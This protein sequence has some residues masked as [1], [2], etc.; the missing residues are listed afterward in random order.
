MEYLCSKEGSSEYT[1]HILNKSLTLIDLFKIF[2]SCMP[3]IEIILEHLPRLL[4]RSYS[5]VNSKQNN[6]NFLKICFSVMD[7]G[8]D[9]KGLTTGW[10][11]EIILKKSNIEDKM[12]QLS[13]NNKSIEVPI[14]IRKN[15]NGFNLPENKET[16][17]ILIG[18]GT[19]VS[20]F[21]GFL[22]EREHLLL[23]DSEGKF[24]FVW[25]FFGCRN[26]ELDFIYEDEL[27]KFVSKG[28]VNKLSTAFSRC[29]NAE[30]CYVQVYF[31]F[32]INV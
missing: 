1:T 32:I 28:V 4:P 10:L 5:I 16:P 2:K 3:P 18:P 29:E 27:K 19:G 15:L 7:I 26:P 30:F 14:Y 12:E 31:T 17:L 24:G 23:K 11:E 6:P 13:L 25:L 9:R 20:P 8:N 21:I 22:E